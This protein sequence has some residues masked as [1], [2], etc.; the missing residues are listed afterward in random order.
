MTQE[1]LHRLARLDFSLLSYT[2]QNQTSSF[3]WHLSICNNYK[4]FCGGPY[5]MFGCEP[6][7]LVYLEFVDFQ[8]GM[9]VK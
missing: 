7:L 5:C 8:T 6:Y 3:I 2:K 1:S 9:A 4:I